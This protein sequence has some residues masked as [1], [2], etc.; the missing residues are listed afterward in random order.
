MHPA[1]SPALRFAIRYKNGAD[2]KMVGVFLTATPNHQK[3]D[4]V[5]ASH[6]LSLRK[7]LHSR[8][9]GMRHILETVLLGCVRVARSTGPRFEYG[10]QRAASRYVP[11]GHGAI[12]AAFRRSNLS[13]SALNVL[14]SS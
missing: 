5:F 3:S 12:M 13:L 4:A 7:R 10:H 8:H 6:T 1:G 11:T 2:F 14:W 9:Q